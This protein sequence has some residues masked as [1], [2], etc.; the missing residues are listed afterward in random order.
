VALGDGHFA[1]RQVKMG[2]SSDDGMVQ[3]V[4]GLAAGDEVVTSGQFLIDSESRMREAL[5]RFET[6]EGSKGSSGPRRAEPLGRPMPS[7]DAVVRAY[8]DIADALGAEQKKPDA[9]SV[10]A[11]LASMAPLKAEAEGSALV[12]PVRSLSEI[13]LRMKGEG[14]DAQRSSFK[15]LSDLMIT[16]V[17]AAPPSSAVGDSLFVMEC[18]MFPGR[19]IQRKEDLANPYYANDMKECGSH[20]KVIKTR[21]GDSK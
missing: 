11:L 1:P 18:P 2:L 17:E 6:N 15:A 20:V 7:V 12:A 13:A 14:V 16:L 19:W 21:A 10:A 5:R 3:I 4:S 8:L 9:I